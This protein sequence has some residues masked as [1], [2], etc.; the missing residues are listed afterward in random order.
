MK[1][2]SV[3]ICVLTYN[4]LE[5]LRRCIWSI[6]MTT[7]IPFR[8]Y[9]LSDNSTDGTDEWLREMKKHSKLNGVIYNEKNLGTVKS[10]NRVITSTDSEWFIAVCDDMYFYRG[11]DE[12]AI[13]IAEGFDDCGMVS[14]WDFPIEPSFVE[15]KKVNDHA[16]I[17]QKTG[18]A[19]T[20]MYRPLFD[21]VGGYELPEGFKMGY[22]AKGFCNKATEL[23][24]TG[25]IE[26]WKQ[27]ITIKEWAVQMDR[28]E[29]YAQE[30]LYE[31]Y[32]DIRDKEKLRHKLYKPK[33][34]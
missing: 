13:K 3:D 31:Q 4:R 24:T 20:L 17:R 2:D 14:F 21:M 8:L 19:C 7:K 11:W 30:H 32:N 10:F 26:R 1:I 33:E 27:Y 6:I 22:F 23:G 18:L 29:A 25:K 5:Y 28:T 15:R 9:V 34:E 16:Y 12:V